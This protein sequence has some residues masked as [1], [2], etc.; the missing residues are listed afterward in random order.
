MMTKR[1]TLALTAVLAAGLS[2]MAI[3][4]AEDDRRHPRRDQHPE[5]AG[6]V[7]RHADLLR[8]RPHRV[9]GAAVY[10]YMDRARAVQAYVST[11][12]GVSQHAM[13]QGGRDIGAAKSN[14][15]LIWDKLANF[16][17][18]ILTGNTST[19]YTWT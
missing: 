6:D 12:P 3:A 18:L 11:A 16:A 5:Q 2:P 15:I 7:D 10:D 19:I 4:E 9:H 13:R 1:M 14:Q 17:S 8:W